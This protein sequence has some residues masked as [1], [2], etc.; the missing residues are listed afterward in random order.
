MEALQDEKVRLAP[1]LRVVVLGPAPADLVRLLWD[2]GLRP[3]RGRA[4]ATVWMV[5]KVTAP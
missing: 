4:D 1:G 2:L 5:P 3:V